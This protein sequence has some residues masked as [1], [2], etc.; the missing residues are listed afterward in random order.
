MSK[1]VTHEDFMKHK[2]RFNVNLEIVGKY[3]KSSEKIECRCKLC[4][5]QIFMLPDNIKRGSGCQDCYHRLS[6]VKRTK[7]T[8]SFIS[9]MKEVN[10][11]IMIVGEY[12]GSHTQIECLCLIHDETFYGSP[13]HLLNNK[14]GCKFCWPKKISSKLMK[15]EEQFAEELRLLHP[16]IKPISKYSGAKNNITVLC[17][18]CGYTWTPEA[19][20]LLS[21]FGCPFCSRSNP[22]KDVDRFLSD[23][24]ISF[25]P[26]MTFDDL[27]GKR[28]VRL[29]YDFYIPDVN[30]LVE[31]QGRFH[32]GSVEIANDYFPR[33]KELDKKKK[34]Y[35]LNNGYNF[36]EIWYY[37]DNPK[38]R[39]LQTINDLKD[40][41]TTTAI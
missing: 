20:S 28:N 4:G 17:E 16:K 12:T 9:E 13:T 11:S 33:R 14:T 8:E 24:K 37:E 35:A 40:P 1:K 36:I 31:Y 25:I 2:N 30:L 5:K 21:G 34:E 22:E 18:E 27:R 41:V 6:G 19:T 39:L 38:E 29:S 7:T 15:P 26:Q 23:H 10:D 3:T 32:D